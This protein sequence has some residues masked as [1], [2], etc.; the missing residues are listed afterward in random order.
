M[1]R[2]LPSQG[3]APFNAA[4]DSPVSRPSL[5]GLPTSLAV[6]IESSMVEI[7]AINW[8]FLSNAPNAKHPDLALSSLGHA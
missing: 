4:T 7:V 3:E 8:N 5:S 6:P 2:G 1:L